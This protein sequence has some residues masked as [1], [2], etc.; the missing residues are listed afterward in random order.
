MPDWRLKAALQKTLSK[1]PGGQ[2]ANYAMQRATGG[3]PIPEAK[4]VETVQHARRH[5]AIARE[6][7]DGD[8]ADSRFFEFGAGWDL[9]IPVVMYVLGAGRQHVVDLQRLARPDL[10]LDTSARIGGL[11][12]DGATRSP[13]IES[14]AS[15]DERLQAMDIRY[16]APADA[17]ATGLQEGAVDIVTSTNTLEH[18]PAEDIRRILR[19][20]RRILRPGGILSARI[21]YQDHY[22]YFDG[23]VSV[24][25]FLRYSERRWRWFNNDL[26]FQNR[27]RH[28]R[29]LELVRD[30]GFELLAVD[31]FHAS[32]ADLAEL[33]SI[34]LAPEFRGEREGDLAIRGSWIVATPRRA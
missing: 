22:S 17:R 2:R 3:L 33:R 7:L 12:L 27:L 9:H 26:H 25:N 28:A 10:V 15:L 6:H 16:R 8:L 24:Y 31:P 21:D 18:V 19:E 4:L 23:R 1:I 14:G 34:P 30:A 11:G 13:M 20:M 5:I 29:Y 32:P